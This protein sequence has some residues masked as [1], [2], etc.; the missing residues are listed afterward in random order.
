[1]FSY[2]YFISNVGMGQFEN[3]HTHQLVS[4][5]PNPYKYYTLA[6]VIAATK[7]PVD[8]CLFHRAKLYVYFARSQVA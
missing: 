6:V 8:C 1:M 5:A 4:W 2:T 3:V 7:V